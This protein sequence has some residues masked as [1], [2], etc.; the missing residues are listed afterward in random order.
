[1][2]LCS[3]Q[4][5]QRAITRLNEDYSNTGLA[6]SLVNTTRTLNP[7]WFENV[8]P[9]STLQDDMKKQLRQGGASA[10]NIYS[11]S[12]H[13]AEDMD[14][15][16]LG[17]STFPANYTSSPTDDGVVVRYNILPGESGAEFGVSKVNDYI[18]HTQG[19]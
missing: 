14:S 6:F 11:V 16:L 13:V 5:I 4:A 15:V 17:D 10:L 19:M 9:G 8:Q 18:V 12:F 7:E 2:H 3:E 1:M